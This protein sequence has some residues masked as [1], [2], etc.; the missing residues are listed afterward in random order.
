MNQTQAATFWGWAALLGTPVLALTNLSASYALVA[1]AC[2]HQQIGILHG[3]A[4]FCLVLSAIV[5]LGSARAA[6]TSFLALIGA[7][8]GTLLTLVIAAQWVPVWML[9][10]CD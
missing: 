6:G 4:A 2:A 9:S 3:L 5:T 7:L 10:P 8:T 1:P